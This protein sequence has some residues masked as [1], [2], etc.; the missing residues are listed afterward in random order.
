M[1]KKMPLVRRKEKAE[2]ET[3]Y[4]RRKCRKQ[5]KLIRAQWRDM[6][7]KY[8]SRMKEKEEESVAYTNLPPPGAQ[9][10]GR[11]PPPAPQALQAI[12]NMI[13]AKR[14]EDSMQAGSGRIH[15][16]DMEEGTLTTAQEALVAPGNPTVF[17]HPTQIIIAGP[18]KTGKT[19]LTK[20]LLQEKDHVLPGAEK[21][22]WYYRIE[23]SVASLKKE[24]PGVEFIQG[25][26]SI[27]NYKKLNDG[28]GR[29][30]ILDDMQDAALD[31]KQYKD[32]IEFFSWIS[33]HK[34]VSIIFLVQDFHLSKNMTRLANQSE[35]VIVMCNGSA[36]YQMGKIAT[37]LFGPKNQDFINWSV[38]HARQNSKYAYLVFATGSET[39]ECQRLKT[40]IFPGE[41]N[42]FYI[43][44][45]TVKSKDY[46]K[47]KYGSS[48]ED[49][50]LRD[51][52]I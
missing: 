33:H 46:L 20:R 4:A 19:T 41:E 2:K 52:K 8:R 38:H 16:F 23:D 27:A 3:P 9:A 24:F 48:G 25:F 49:E 6:Q 21:V 12:V 30:V 34:K 1:H 45:D 29:L 7:R 28:V 43:P 47:L 51:S 50:A 10:G 15:Q 22:V 5:E 17:G 32:L 42:T 13:K 37:K 40:K 11:V 14:Q 39:P 31:T 26:P 18:T 36:Q 35:N 44:K